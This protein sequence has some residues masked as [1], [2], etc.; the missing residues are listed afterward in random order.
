MIILPK[1]FKDDI[2][3]LAK[4][5]IE[6]NID[7][8]VELGDL[9]ISFFKNFPKPAV[10]INNFKITGK[11]VFENNTLI[12]IGEAVAQI[13]LS[14][15][16][17][18]EEGIEISKIS[19]K[20]TDLDIQ[21]LEN[22]IANYDIT[23]SYSETENYNEDQVNNSGINLELKA[24][25]ISNFNLSYKDM[26]EEI[27]ADIKQ[28]N[29]KG[30]IKIS[31]N[32][33]LIESES[34]IESLSIEYGDINYLNETALSATINCLANLDKMIFTLKENAI[35]LNALSLNAEGFVDLEDDRIITDL[36]F[37]APGNSF[38]ELFSLVPAAY[39]EDYKDIDFEGSFK[40]DGMIKGA[41]YEEH[42][43]AI[44][45]DI[46][47]NNGAVK[48]PDLPFPIK[49]INT[50][51]KI[52]KSEGDIDK[53]KIDIPA[54][55]MNLQEQILAG[56]FKL[57]TPLSNPS[58]DMDLNG[59]LDLNALG[60]AFPIEDI[61]ALEGV[62]TADFNFKANYKQFENEAYE[63]MEVGG[64]VSLIDFK[65]IAYDYPP[66]S[67]DALEAKFTPQEISINDFSS[68][69]GQSDIRGYGYIENLLAY[70]YPEQ[71]MKGAFTIQS[72]YFNADEWLTEPESPKEEQKE[73]IIDGSEDESLT[74][75]PVEKF[76]FTLPLSEQERGPGL[77][78][79]F[80]VSFPTTF[81]CS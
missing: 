14:S 29:T 51:V 3:A 44:K 49:D 52:H 59:T 77:S 78:L 35:Q 10:T 47:A 26:Q 36:R 55:S 22:G 39:I 71:T 80:S 20:D 81:V 65:T 37:S 50:Q 45:L 41:Y 31:D 27:F 28:L 7:A 43:P 46:S 79:P 76:D 63:Q 57:S 72:N 68:T 40:L 11:G 73:E 74:T 30:F 61:K 67:I 1:V 33:Y 6:R 23:T 75:L 70:F 62:L 25:K 18:M 60:K 15:L 66:V 19:I 24:L 9:Q 48:Y 4:K 8:H 13:D 34:D 2:Y 16:L 38:G 21:V 54:F 56:K 5:E 17:N 64:A 58:M 32:E 53:L 42:Y 69:L 12:Q